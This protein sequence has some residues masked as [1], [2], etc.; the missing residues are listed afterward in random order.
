MQ[1]TTSKIQPTKKIK[2]EY[3]PVK[4]CISDFLSVLMKYCQLITSTHN[5]PRMS[6]TFVT[7]CINIQWTYTKTIKG[8]VNGGETSDQLLCSSNRYFSQTKHGTILYY[9]L[10]IDDYKVPKS[11]HS[12]FLTR[13]AK[14][15]ISSS[16]CEKSKANSEISKSR[17]SYICFASTFPSRKAI[18]K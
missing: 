9:F 16:K 12:S 18:L 6:E 15:K 10:V 7:N 14:A 11:L 8:P 17:R 5:W 1:N 13:K 3:L 4:E 2:N